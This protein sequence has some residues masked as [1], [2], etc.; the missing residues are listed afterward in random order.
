MMA[1]VDADNE[2][3]FGAAASRGGD[4]CES[5]VSLS[6]GS[7][8]VVTLKENDSYNN[9]TAEVEDPGWSC[10]RCTFLNH[11]ALHA[12]ECCLLERFSEPSE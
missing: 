5:V 6:H 2:S 9:N 7:K 8:S 12:C 3:S 4:G 10:A 1:A 11:P